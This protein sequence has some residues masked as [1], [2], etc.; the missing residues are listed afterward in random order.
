M[1]AKDI[2]DFAAWANVQVSGRLTTA[3]QTLPVHI[4]WQAANGERVPCQNC[5]TY[6]LKPWGNTVTYGDTTTHI[7]VA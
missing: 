6:P 2:G 4:G 3:P 7:V 5:V 1:N